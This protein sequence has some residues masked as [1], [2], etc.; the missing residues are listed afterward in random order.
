MGNWDKQYP[1]ISRKCEDN[2]FEFSAFFDYPAGIRIMIT[3]INTIE[4]LNPFHAKENE[5]PRR[6]YKR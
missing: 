6:Y 3:T 4:A 2:W 5:N 1:E